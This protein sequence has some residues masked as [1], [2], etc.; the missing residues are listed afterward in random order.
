MP[1]LWWISGEILLIVYCTTQIYLLCH[2]YIP[3]TPSTHWLQHCFSDYSIFFISDYS[4]CSMIYSIS[5][6]DYHIGFLITALILWSQHLLYDLQHCFSDYS[7]C[8]MIQHCFSDKSIV[9]L[10]T[11]FFL[12]LQH[13]FYDLQRWFYDYRICFLITA[14]FLWL[15]RCFSDYNRVCQNSVDT[16]FRNNYENTNMFNPGYPKNFQIWTS[17][18]LNRVR[19]YTIQ[20]TV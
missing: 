19:I 9:F 15:Q 1:R 17:T 5:S 6:Y 13:L 3:A 7:I 8:Y 10:M 2:C 11:A 14:F 18:N 16:I 20:Y 4:I 12:W